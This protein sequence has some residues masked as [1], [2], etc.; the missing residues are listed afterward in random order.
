MPDLPDGAYRW[1]VN[2]EISKVQLQNMTNAAFFSLTGFIALLVIFKVLSMI[3][4]MSFY[5]GA[6][7]TIIIAWFLWNIF[8]KTNSRMHLLNMV[9]IGEGHPWHPS[10]KIGDTSV[11][12]SDG[13]EWH[14]IPKKARLFAT[15]D[16]ILER[17]LLKKNDENGEILLIWPDSLDLKVRKVVSLVN[18]ALAFQDAQDR[19]EGELDPIETARAR[20]SQEFYPM[21]RKWEETTPGSLIPQPG[22]L[23]RQMKGKGFDII[24]KDNE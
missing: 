3:G 6:V 9:A 22:A 12:V 5:S 21:E 10:E 2:P 8:L 13:D 1:S 17:T 16:P 7:F 15:A 4:L 24:E 20:E 11:W 18:Q 14:L 23:I 19:D